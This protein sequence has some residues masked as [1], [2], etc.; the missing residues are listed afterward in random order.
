MAAWPQAKKMKKKN[1][2]RTLWNSCW[3][4]MQLSQI[5]NSDQKRKCFLSRTDVVVWMARTTIIILVS[6]LWNG[7]E[8]AK[9][10]SLRR[11]GFVIR[12][13]L[14][15]QAASLDLWWRGSLK[16]TGRKGW[17]W[18]RRSLLDLLRKVITPST[19]QQPPPSLSLCILAA[20]W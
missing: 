15:W 12:I 2:K 6:H 20:K 7:F 5:Y 8:K 16:E 4:S 1:E 14:P 3:S 11:P 18:S 17:R 13:G 10:I 9:S 19:S